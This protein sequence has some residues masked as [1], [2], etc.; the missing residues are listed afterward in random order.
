M[1]S[2]RQLS[3]FWVVLPVVCDCH[4]SPH[5]GSPQLGQGGNGSLQPQARGPQAAQ[6]MHY[7]LHTQAHTPEHTRSTFSKM[8]DF[9][10]VNKC[11]TFSSSYLC[12]VTL[13]EHRRVQVQVLTVLHLDPA[14]HIIKQSTSASQ[15]TDDL[16]LHLQVTPQHQFLPSSSRVRLRAHLASNRNP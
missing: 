4:L 1:P 5:A 12:F 8:S 15:K 3:G 11:A 13:Q 10:T 2:K 9:H 7:I 14:Q 6:Y 16:W